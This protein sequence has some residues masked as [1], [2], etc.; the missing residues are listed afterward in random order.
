[1]SRRPYI[2]ILVV[3]LVAIAATVG[4][5]YYK[6]MPQVSKDETK[7]ML[8]GYKADLEEKYAVLNDT[9][10]QLS[11]TKNTEGW[12]S[13]SSE[14]IPELSGIRPA[15][16]DKR[17]PSDYEGKKNVLVST[18]GAL[19]SLWTEYNRDFLENDATNQERVKEMK[20]GIEDVFE[21]LEI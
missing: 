3:L 21:N 2:I 5:M 4:Y 18:Q 15:D 7:E 17:L 9:Y 19:I 13:F 12:Q 10:E 8:E 20:S 11:V 14:W 6:K 16:I 1:M